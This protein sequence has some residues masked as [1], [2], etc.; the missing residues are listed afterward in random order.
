MGYVVCLLISKAE[1][2]I[3]NIMEIQ[4]TSLPFE[5]L[6]IPQKQKNMLQALVQEQTL[7]L[8]SAYFDD[9]IEGKGKGFIILLQ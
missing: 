4:W 9:M 1:F 7:S 6:V 8:E 2:A 3:F 5:R